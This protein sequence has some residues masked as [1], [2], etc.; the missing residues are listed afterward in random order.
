MTDG[1][2]GPNAVSRIHC[3]A[4]R[5]RTA[6]G[7]T[8]PKASGADRMAGK[9]TFLERLI[10][11]LRGEGAAVRDS[12]EATGASSSPETPLGLDWATYQAN[13]RELLRYEGQ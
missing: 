9:R 6:E 3:R 10:S 1:F 13:K 4:P 2:S 11:L 8:T 12:N 5:P 7:I